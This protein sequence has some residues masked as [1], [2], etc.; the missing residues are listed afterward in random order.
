MTTQRQNSLYLFRKNGGQIL[1][2]ALIGSLTASNLSDGKMYCNIA[3]KLLEG[4]LGSDYDK[5]IVY[6]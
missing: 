4:F 6:S 3:K 5:A 1:S 2:E